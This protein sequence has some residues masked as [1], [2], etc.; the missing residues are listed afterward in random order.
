[1]SYHLTAVRKNIIKKS[2]SKMLERVWRKTTSYTVSGNV[3]R[4]S[5][6][7]EQYGGFL[8]KKKKN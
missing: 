2:T 7:E 3:N 1:M 6:Y 8:Q 5:P 4:C